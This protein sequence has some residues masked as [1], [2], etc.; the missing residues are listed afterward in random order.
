M[1]N[2]VEVKKKDSETSESLIRR[3]SKKVQQSGVLIRAKKSRFHEPV[4]NKRKSKDDALR[5]KD[6]KSKKEY[7][8]KIG[9]LED[10]DRSK[11]RGGRR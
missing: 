1:N 8:R 6:I 4:K 10:F 9:K 7:L 5:R 2:V 11:K 3:F